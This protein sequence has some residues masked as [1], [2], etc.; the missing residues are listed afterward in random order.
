N[1]WVEYD[2]TSLVNGSGTYSFDIATDSTDGVYFSQREASTFRPELVITTGTPDTQ[3]PTAPGSLTA[4]AIGPNRIDLG[5]LTSTDNTAV[6]G[7]NVYR[8]GTLLA[9]IGATNSYSDTGVSPG[10][11][12]SYQVRALDAA[13]N[14]SDPSNTASATTPSAATVLTLSPDADAIV[15]QASAT[16]NYAT[17]VLG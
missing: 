15:R 8:G 4:N 5:W 17:D 3:K 9:G 11:G 16:T 13:G 12:Y 10:I 7:Y 1:T 14:I 6:T 2:V